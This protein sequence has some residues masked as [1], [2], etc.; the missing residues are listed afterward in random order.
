[1]YVDIP[2]RVEYDD[3]DA[4][5]DAV[6]AALDAVANTPGVDYAWVYGGWPPLD[7]K[8]FDGIY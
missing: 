1:M 7:E 5:E 4:V 2:L 8:V 3:P 6:E